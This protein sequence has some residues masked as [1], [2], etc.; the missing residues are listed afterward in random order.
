[1]SREQRKTVGEFV[2]RDLSLWIGVIAAL[3]GV[4]NYVSA[5]KNDIKVIETLNNIRDNHIHTIEG[6]IEDQDVEISKLRDQ[7]TRIETIL[8]ERLPAKIK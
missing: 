4:F 3:F 1:M 8:E 7:V 2:Y 6:S 5:P